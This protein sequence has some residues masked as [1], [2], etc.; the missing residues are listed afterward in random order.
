M[1]TKDLDPNKALTPEGSRGRDR[2]VSGAIGAGTGAAI[3]TAVAPG[4]GTAIGAGIGGLAGLIFGDD[5]TVLP[6]DMVAIPAFEAYMITGN[7]SFRLY[8]RA[9]ETIVPTGGNVD[10]VELGIAENVAPQRRERKKPTQK[11]DW[12]KYIGNK[13]N[14]IR[15]KTGKKKGLLNMKAMGRE[16]RKKKKK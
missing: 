11:S 9:G 14:Q 2:V 3:G 15:F 6:V 12:H 1:A 10:D 16:Y 5:N 13:K 7:P 4:I 8:I